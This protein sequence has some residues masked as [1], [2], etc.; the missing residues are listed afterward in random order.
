MPVGCVVLHNVH[1]LVLM[2]SL[3]FFL[4]IRRPPRSTLFPYTTLFRSKPLSGDGFLGVVTTFPPK[5]SGIYHAGSVDFMHRFAKGF[6]FR[7]N[8]TFEKNIDNST[9]ELFSSFVNPRRAQDGFNFANERGRSVLDLP[10]KFAVTWV[11]DLPNVKTENRL[12]GGLAHGWE[13]SGTYLAQSGQPVTALSGVDSN[14]NGDTAGDRTILNPT[15]VGLTGS[16]VTAVCNNGLA[17][18][19]ITYIDPTCDPNHSDDPPKG[20]TGSCTDPTPGSPAA[21]VGYLA[22]TPGARFIQ[23]GVG[24]KANVGRNTVSSPGLNIWNMSLFKTNRL[25]ERSSLQ[26]RFQTYE[27]FNHRNYSIGLPTNNGAI[28]SAN[29]T[30]PLNGGYIFVTSPTFLNKF[31]FD[32]GN[33]TLELGI[34]LTW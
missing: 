18:G 22:D 10:Q 12:L 25:S 6:Y 31:S 7:A 11:Y 29:N 33:R 8:Y 1:S 34:K 17:G 21:V 4:M 15:G 3:F 2:T 30:N 13:L 14:A 5:G 27:T 9:N 16:T 23:A 26:F 32:G 19:G 20:C 24:A 28:D